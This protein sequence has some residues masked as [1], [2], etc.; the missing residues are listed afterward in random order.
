MD[1]LNLPFF[2]EIQKSVI[3]TL[4]VISLKYICR[5]HTGDRPYKC[6]QPGCDKAFTQLSNLQVRHNLKLFI[7]YSDVPKTHLLRFVEKRGGELFLLSLHCSEINVLM[8]L[9]TSNTLY[10]NSICTIGE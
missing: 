3:I 5:I 2:L 7:W 6:I 10:L 9:K 1:L 8:N 4:F